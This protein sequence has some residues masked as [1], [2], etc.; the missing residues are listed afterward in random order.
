MKTQKILILSIW[1]GFYLCLNIAHAGGW[2]WNKNNPQHNES[3]QDVYEAQTDWKTALEKI[4]RQVENDYFSFTRSYDLKTPGLN[5][6]RRIQTYSRLRSE[7]MLAGEPILSV[8]VV[9]EIILDVLD[10]NAHPMKRD[11]LTYISKMIADQLNQNPKIELVNRNQSEAVN[12]ELHFQMSELVDPATAARLG[13]LRGVRYLVV[14]TAESTAKDSDIFVQVVDVETAEELPPLFRNQ[15]GV[16]SVRAFMENAQNYNVLYENYPRDQ[17]EEE[18][19]GKPLETKVQEESTVGEPTKEQLSQDRL[20]PPPPPLQPPPLRPRTKLEFYDMLRKDF[21]I[22]VYF[23]EKLKDLYK[24]IPES[25][26]RFEETLFLDLYKRILSG[27]TVLLDNK[28]KK[29]HREDSEVFNNYGTAHGFYP[30][31]DFSDP[32]LELSSCEHIQTH[33]EAA[34]ASGILLEFAKAYDKLPRSQQSEIRKLYPTIDLHFLSWNDDY[35]DQYDIEQYK[36]WGN[37]YPLSRYMRLNKEGGEIYLFTQWGIDLMPLTKEIYPVLENQRG[38]E[39]FYDQA[40]FRWLYDFPSYSHNASFHLRNQVDRELEAIDVFSFTAGTALIETHDQ[41]ERAGNFAFDFLTYD[42]G[43]KNGRILRGSILQSDAF[44]GE[45]ET[46]RQTLSVLQGA[47]PHAS[48]LVQQVFWGYELEGYSLEEDRIRGYLLK[49]WL[50]GGVLATYYPMMSRNIRFGLRGHGSPFQHQV[51]MEFPNAQ[52]PEDQRERLNSRYGLDANICIAN[53]NQTLV[54][55]FGVGEERFD[56]SKKDDL[57]RLRKYAQLN[58]H[59]WG[60]VQ[61]KYRYAEPIIWLNFE[62]SQDEWQQLKNEF[63]PSQK[64]WSLNL[65]FDF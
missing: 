59:M 20:L 58:Y 17:K 31:L 2:S 21:K 30:Y 54:C 43:Q 18:V 19:S 44:T 46:H 27:K 49:D 6:S 55:N 14:V 48:E 40:T 16:Y 45:Q 22:R 38:R 32:S 36:R 24:K 33:L 7:Y 1:V 64:T 23:S 29:C 28:N 51:Q 15:S 9:D 52:M 53:L 35:M 50:H 34:D 3:S 13:R 8:A 56:L 60:N 57:I 26:R 47:L 62:Y 12:K 41:K 11:T 4:A 65:R 25:M 63:L 37:P 5:T 42:D 39:S 10:A 61:N